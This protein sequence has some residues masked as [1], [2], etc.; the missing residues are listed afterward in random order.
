MFVWFLDFFFNKKNLL[1]GREKRKG[2]ERGV[3][4][5]HMFFFFFFFE[6]MYEGGKGQRTVWI[7]GNGSVDLCVCVCT[8][9]NI[10]YFSLFFR[11]KAQ[12]FE[13]CVIRGCLARRVC[14]KGWKK[15]PNSNYFRE[16]ARTIFEFFFFHPPM[17][18]EG[19]EGDYY[20]ILR[21]VKTFCFLFLHAKLGRTWVLLDNLITMDAPP[22][23]RA[24]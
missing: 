22:D 10:S 4:T 5:C 7:R 18:Q 21:K 20:A 12:A 13:R 9:G 3:K 17:G 8:F 11:V 14:W 1:G 19:G 2:K 24:I 15:S 6:I 23:P 16:G